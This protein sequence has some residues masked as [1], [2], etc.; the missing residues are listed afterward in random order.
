MSIDDISAAMDT[1]IMERLSVRGSGD[2]TQMR[3]LHPNTVS[4][5]GPPTLVCQHSGSNTTDLKC[6]HYPLVEV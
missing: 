5:Q 2:G 4:T 1:N 3:G 6:S